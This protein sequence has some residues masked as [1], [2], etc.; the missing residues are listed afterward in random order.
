MTSKRFAASLVF[1][2]ALACGEAEPSD[3]APATVDTPRVEVAQVAGLALA[4]EEKVAEDEREAAPP[5]PL[6]DRPPAKASEVSLRF[7]GDIIFGRYRDAGFDAIVEPLSEEE[8][9]GSNASLEGAPFAKMGDALEADVVVANLETPV[10]ETL[11][12]RSPS[13]ADYRFGASRE[14]ASMLRPAGF[15]VLSLANN[16]HNDLRGPGHEQSAKI[17]RELGHTPMGEAQAEAPALR[18]VTHE[19]QGWRIAFVALTSKLNMGLDPAPPHIPFVETKALRAELA[20]ENGLIAK[21]REGHDLVVVSLHWG[22]EYTDPPSPRQR[23]A[24]RALIDAGADVVFGHHPHV[25]Q[26]VEHY[27]GG[28]IAYSMGNFLFENASPIP[29]LTGVLGLSF[30]APREAGGRA[31]LR[32]GHFFPAI[33]Q[34]KPYHH[35][36]PAKGL[37][38]RKV[39]E[40]LVTLSRELRT[41]W[42]SPGD[43][44]PLEL[45]VDSPC[46]D[47]PTR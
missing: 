22:E 25:L 39:S 30:A 13:H 46:A 37:G 47:V 36:A 2:F 3:P 41:T 42:T 33:M 28:I 12:E 29:K 31:C 35:P 14:M 8:L 23:K 38:Y 32:S 16:H 45:S 34:R 40:R 9:A 11:P 5:E 17:L 26:G 10:V 44:A 18:V 4:N 19:E 43:A 1:I 21:A 20:G 15:D 7:A 27:K 24:A 6:P